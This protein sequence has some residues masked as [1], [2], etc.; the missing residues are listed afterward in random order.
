MFKQCILV[1]GE[2]AST[3]GR[4]ETESNRSNPHV[5]NLEH[6]ERAQSKNL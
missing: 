1:V 3:T 6:F 5:L 2:L 4:N